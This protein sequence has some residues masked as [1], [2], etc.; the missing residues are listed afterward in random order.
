[1][2]N[3]QNELLEYLETLQRDFK[4]AR[5]VTPSLLDDT[6]SKFN[7]Q[8]QEAFKTIAEGELLVPVIGGFSAGKSSAINQLLGEEILPVAVT[9][10]TAIPAELRYSTTPQIIAVRTNGEE[11]QHTVNAMPGLSENADDYEVVRIYLDNPILKELEPF[12]LVDMPGYDSTLDQHNRA[13]LRYLT[14]GAFYLYMVS[15]QDGTLNA[16][17]LARL[18]EIRDNGHNFTVLMSKKD[19]SSPNELEEVMTHVQDQINLEFG[20]NVVV[21][22]ISLSDVSPL[23]KAVLNASPDLLFDN[24][25][26]SK[27]KDLFYQ[28]QGEI[29]SAIAALK[30]SK[31]EGLNKIEELQQALTDMEKERDKKLQE[32]QSGTLS[33]A[34]NRIA[35][36]IERDLESASTDF[37]RLAKTSEDALSRSISDHVR[38]ALMVEMR[39]EV[40]RV[41]ND[42]A[43]T[44]ADKLNVSLPSDFHPS[45]D[46]LNNLVG[47]LQSEVMNALTA[48][49]VN[50]DNAP[51]SMPNSGRNIGGGLGN[52]AV[53]IPHPVIKVIMMIL[54]GII[55]TLFDQFSTSQENKKYQD[56]IV[57]Q[58]IPSVMAQV[59]PQIADALVQVND[60]LTNAISQEFETKI[61]RQQDIYN[62][63]QKENER[64]TDE[65]EHELAELNNIRNSLNT[66]AEKFIA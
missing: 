13:I 54:P 1:M 62:K 9:A 61:Q 53:M 63:A 32:V 11:E 10:E 15:Y 60:S 46:W 7:V 20:A 16:K 8:Y 5:A 42:I 33:E 31:E 45:D 66:Q 24:K 22:D 28:A 26:T 18:H 64:Q 12:T 19:L 34:E 56:A 49:A 14:R 44:F 37:V 35:K 30:T 21:T 38:S 39:K 51:S 52:L 4:K 55:G 17:H 27:A 41:S 6:F 23:K 47:D 2:I 3:R 36:H 29:N 25:Y 50:Q 58:V 57:S 59:R 43:R 48:G 40:G 65:L